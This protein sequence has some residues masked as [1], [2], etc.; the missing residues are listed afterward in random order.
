MKIILSV[1]LAV[2]SISA[3]A[4]QPM[5]QDV[6]RRLRGQLAETPSDVRPTALPEFYGVYFGGT[7]QPRTFVDAELS[8]IG[9]H[10]TGYS[11]LSGPQRGTDINTDETNRLFRHMI[12]TIPENK[13]PVR[14][15]GAGQRK[16]YLFTAYDCPSCRAV[17]DRMAREAKRLNATVVIVPTALAFERDPN[18][19]HLLKGVLCASNRSDAWRKLLATRSVASDAACDTRPEDFV[20]LWRVFPV[21]FPSSVPTALLPDGKVYPLVLRDFDEIFKG[22]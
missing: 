7:A 21:R 2:I 14:S 17:E 20:Y 12:Q 9:N 5:E 18:A 11:F 16:V 15:F 10:A 1:L 4:A 19:R 22:Q 13:L 3:G 8:V 6:F